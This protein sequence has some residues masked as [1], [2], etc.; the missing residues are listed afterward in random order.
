MKLKLGK[1]TTGHLDAWKSTVTILTIISALLPK[2]W[3]SVLRATSRTLEAIHV[4]TQPESDEGKRITAEEVETIAA[5][6]LDY[7]KD[8]AG[9]A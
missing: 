6:F 8:E 9:I 5:A 1:L 4:A 7:L 3:S 2:P